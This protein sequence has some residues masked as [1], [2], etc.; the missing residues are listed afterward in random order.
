MWSWSWDCCVCF[1]AS[2][3]TSLVGVEVV[4]SLMIKVA[5]GGGIKLL[6]LMFKNE[7]YDFAVVL[8]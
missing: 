6:I 1:T 8:A 3:S 7:V 5:N 2:I 4:G